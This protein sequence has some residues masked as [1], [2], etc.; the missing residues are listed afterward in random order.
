MTNLSKMAEYKFSLQNQV[1]FL[2]TNSKLPKEEVDHG[3]VPI[4]N[5]TKDNRRSQHK[6]NQ[7]DDRPLKCKLQLS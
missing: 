3:L 7:G 2:Y 1:A 4:Y 6:P 5:T